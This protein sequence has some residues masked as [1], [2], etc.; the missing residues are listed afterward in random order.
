MAA[1]T[2][3]AAPTAST[4]LA[5]VGLVPISTLTA[6]PGWKPLPLTVALDPAGALSSLTEEL[7]TTAWP[8]GL[9]V[10]VAVA[11]GPTA[12]NSSARPVRAAN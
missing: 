1:F 10:T 11:E 6:L 12:E 7:G 8:P 3:P 2:S 5:L 4:E 9:A